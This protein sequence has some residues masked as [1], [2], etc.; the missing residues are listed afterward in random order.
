MLFFVSSACGCA[1]TAFQHNTCRHATEC[2][3]S[4]RPPTIVLPG[5]WQRSHSVKACALSCSSCIVLIQHYATAATEGTHF[6]RCCTA[7]RR[8]V[9]SLLACIGQ[10]V[11]CSTLTGPMTKSCMPASH[12]ALICRILSTA[13]GCSTSLSTV[14]APC[15][16]SHATT[17]VRQSPNPGA[18][19]H[20]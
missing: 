16:W 5:V 11:Q 19:G 10:V 15:A 2:A 17:F 13:T 4:Q 9:I 20:H 3:S 6:H 18:Q 1:T 12:A 7:T 14:L 8:Q